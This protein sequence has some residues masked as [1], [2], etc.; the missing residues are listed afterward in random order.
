M[1]CW[2][3]VWPAYVTLLTH[4]WL[5]DSWVNWTV[6]KGVS[7]LFLNQ[8][9]CCGYPNNLLW[10]SLSPTIIKR[11]VRFAFCSKVEKVD[12]HLACQRKLGELSLQPF[13]FCCCWRVPRRSCFYTN[14]EVNR[15]NRQVSAHCVI[16]VQHYSARRYLPTWA[17]R[18]SIVCFPYDFKYHFCLFRC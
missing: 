8:R 7:P 5:A 9:K 12:V 18:L 14:G 15:V 3:L 4:S 11:K 17:S 2:L 1:K 6:R 10:S 13:V 16:V